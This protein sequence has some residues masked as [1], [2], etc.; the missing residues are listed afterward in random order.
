MSQRGR[1]TRVYDRRQRT[2]YGGGNL[3]VDDDDEL[4]GRA[5]EVEGGIVKEGGSEGRSLL[6][7]PGSSESQSV[8]VDRTPQTNG[9][10]DA[11]TDRWNRADRRGGDAVN[12]NASDEWRKPVQ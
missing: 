5:V 1:E 9:R 4:H 8:D 6:Q 12:G 2:S 10:T 7:D 3:P 11:R